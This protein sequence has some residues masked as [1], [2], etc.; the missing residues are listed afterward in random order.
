MTNAAAG[1]LERLSLDVLFMPLIGAACS[2]A[3]LHLLVHD[4]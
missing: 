1:L 3:Y 2:F 4:S